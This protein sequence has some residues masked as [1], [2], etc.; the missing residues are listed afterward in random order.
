VR[1]RAALRQREAM[2]RLRPKPS[3]A[4]Q[5]LQQAPLDREPAPSYDAMP[6]RDSGGQRPHPLNG[7]RPHDAVQTPCSPSLPSEQQVPSSVS[8][9]PHQLRAQ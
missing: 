1:A 3:A 7:T 5:R 6:G 2:T 9:M 4:A 8:P